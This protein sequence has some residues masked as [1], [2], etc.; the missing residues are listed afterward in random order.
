MYVPFCFPFDIFSN[1]RFEQPTVK[2][3]IFRMQIFINETAYEVDAGLS[4]DSLK[5]MIENREFI[6]A[7][8][9]RLTSAGKILE[10]GTLGANGVADEDELAVALEVEAG[11]RRK[12][13]KKRSKYLYLR[14]SVEFPFNIFGRI[15][16]VP[17]FLSF[18]VSSASF[19]PQASPHASTC[20]INPGYVTVVRGGSFP[21]LLVH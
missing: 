1:S 8:Q 20:Q 11:M 7:D 18:S 13:R 5:A 19:A 12:W 4:V 15:T 14:Y 6:P 10:F 17:Q 16:H 3:A 21:S 2:E 9:I